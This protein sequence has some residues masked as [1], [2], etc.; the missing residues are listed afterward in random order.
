MYIKTAVL[1]LAAGESKRL[2]EPKQL[3]PYKDTNLLIHTIEQ[4]QSLPNTDVFIVVGAHFKDVFDSI[5]N[6][7]VTVIKNNDW[8]KGMGSSLAK[9]IKFIQKKDSFDRV[10]ITLS[11]LP[12]TE[13]PHYAELLDLADESHKRIVITNY[14]NVSGA[15]V[16]FDASLFNEL[17]LLENND[18]AKPVIDKYKREVIKY[19]SKTPFFDV[20]TQAAYQKLLQLTDD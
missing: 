18:G 11:D 16:V 12:L 17:S 10:L 4:V 8:E 20:D 1:I 13:A 9:G 3:L 7:P 6:Q 2:G 5:R 15:P 14:E 19:N